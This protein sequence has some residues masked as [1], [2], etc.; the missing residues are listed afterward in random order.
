M[1]MTVTR[2]GVNEDGTPHYAYVSD[3]HVVLTG[4]I[5]GQVR[6]KDGTVYDV[7]APVIEVACDNPGADGDHSNCHADEVSTAIGDRYLLEGH[8]LVADFDYRNPPDGSDLRA[9]IFKLR[10]EADPHLTVKKGR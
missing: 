4:A 7:T 1:T 6:T 3:G 9:A 2:S 5:Q 10:G 8:P